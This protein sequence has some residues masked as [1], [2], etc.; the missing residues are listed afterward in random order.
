LPRVKEIFV[1][2]MRID[3]RRIEAIS[4]VLKREQRAKSVTAFRD[5][6]RRD[7]LAFAWASR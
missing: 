7:K 1:S 3:S 6:S 5:S 2:Q 4:E